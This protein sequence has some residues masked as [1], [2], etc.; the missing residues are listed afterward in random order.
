M[1]AQPRCGEEAQWAVGGYEEKSPCCDEQPKAQAPEMPRDALRS[2]NTAAHQHANVPRRRKQTHGTHEKDHSDGNS[3][4]SAGSAAHDFKT[5]H[6]VADANLQG[7][8]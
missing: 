8:Q 5:I 7:N 1:L 3:V 6:P 2:K 4:L